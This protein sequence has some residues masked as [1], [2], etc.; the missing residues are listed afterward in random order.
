MMGSMH[1]SLTGGQGA[2]GSCGLV[3]FAVFDELT[4]L[5]ERGKR[6]RYALLRTLIRGIQC[7]DQ[8]ATREAFCRL[9]DVTED[10]GAAL[11]T[12]STGSARIA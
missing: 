4:C 10:L 11:A 1:T 9:F 5:E 7:V 6:I 2:F 3:L 8:F 12:A